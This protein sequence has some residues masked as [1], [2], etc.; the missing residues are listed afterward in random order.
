MTISQR[1]FEI[2]E[3][4]GLKQS[5]L[6]KYVGVASS[7]VTDWKKRGAIPSADKIIK[8]SDFLKTTPEYLLGMT[9][10]PSLPQQNIVNFSSKGDHNTN[11][12]NI[13]T[14]TFDK[15]TLEIAR[16]IRDLPLL[17]RS[18]IVVMIN[19]MKNSD[20]AVIK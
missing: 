12:V 8:I 15:D 20:K 6:A 2:M 17:E 1:I 18:E 4:Q 11:S 14:E 5:D 16:M 13:G 10:D 9:N 3:N 7:S 19:K